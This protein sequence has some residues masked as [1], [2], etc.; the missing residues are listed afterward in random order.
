MMVIKGMDTCCED[1][2]VEV[3][4][5]TITTITIITTAT[6]TS[7]LLAA[8]PPACPPA[9]PPADP[10]VAVALENRGPAVAAAL[11]DALADAVARGV[12]S[13]VSSG[14][15]P[16]VTSVRVL[17]TPAPVAWARALVPSGVNVLGAALFGLLG[18]FG[19]AAWARRQ[20]QGQ[21]QGEGEREREREGP[22]A[23]AA[24]VGSA[25]GGG[26]P[27]Y[28]STTRRRGYASEEA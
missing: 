19:R 15:A 7:T 24:V 18:W 14:V 4:A 23:P 3:V 9:C 16:L 10:A 26:L 28:H 22:V 2:Y 13:G 1:E 20:R 12:A 25:H 5:S 11:A 6:I 8:A 27:L 21:G 17:A